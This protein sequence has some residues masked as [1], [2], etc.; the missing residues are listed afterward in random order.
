MTSAGTDGLVSASATASANPATPPATAWGPRAAATIEV[1][2]AIGTELLR[3]LRQQQPGAGNAS[4]ESHEY[5]QDQSHSGEARQSVLLSAPTRSGPR[6]DEMPAAIQE[7]RV[8]RVAAPL[9]VAPASCSA[10]ADQ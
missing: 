6:V 10:T 5:G 3:D 7:Q 1:A 9:G 4:R 8:V 2:L